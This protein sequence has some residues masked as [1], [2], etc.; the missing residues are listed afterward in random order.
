MNAA[1]PL[2]R[3]NLPML[4]PGE[5]PHQFKTCS[6]D[7]HGPVHRPWQAHAAGAGACPRVSGAAAA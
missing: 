2:Y 7:P 1:Y 4:H 5:A 3:L 6:R